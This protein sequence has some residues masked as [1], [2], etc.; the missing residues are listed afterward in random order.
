[1][2]SKNKTNN[3]TKK[4]SL[5]SFR[6]LQTKLL[7][8]FLLILLIPSLTI[9]FISYKTA[10]DEVEKQILKSVDDNVGMLERAIDD[11]ISS[12]V[13]DIE[14]LAGKITNNMYND[15]EIHNI[16]EL[17]EIYQSV[18]PD[19]S[20]VFTGN[21][22]GAYLNVLKKDPPK[23]YDARK[24]MW[25]IQ[26]M[27]KKGEVIISEPYIAASTGE[28]VITV[29][30]VNADKTGVIGIDISLSQL[31]KV[32]ENIQIGREGYGFILDQNKKYIVHPTAELGS[33]V[34]SN[35]FDQMYNN[36]EGYFETKIDGKNVA[37]SYTTDKLTG[38][39]VVGTI[40]TDEFEEASNPILYTTMIV[41]AVAIL[42]G[43][44]IVIYNSRSIMKSLKLL[45]ETA[46]KVSQG[47]LTNHVEI[48]TNDVIGKLGEAFNEMIDG[49]QN[50]THTMDKTAE[51]VASSSEELLSNAEET[52]AITEQ[53]SKS[54]QD[55]AE[56]AEKQTNVIEETS[57]SLNHVSE[58]ITKIAENSFEVAGLAHRAVVQAED[59]GKAVT[60]TVKQMQS[61]HE[62]V[63]ESH[64]IIKSLNESSKE[65]REILGVI[66][67]IADQT[68]LLALNAAIEA[69]RAGEH[70]KGFAVV[71]DE[72]RKLA[73]QSQASAKEIHAIITRIQSDTENT[74]EIMKHI[75]KDVENGV[76][77]TSEAIEQFNGI[78]ES[79]KEIAPKM[80]EVS[81]AAQRIS[82]EIQEIASSANVI[83]EI[84]Q[85]NAATS[86]EVAASA[87]EQLA[88]MEEISS[89][90]QSLAILADELK[91]IT[92]KFKR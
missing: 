83:V 5:F 49:L 50:I 7:V 88:S 76:E 19:V 47:D 79:T 42:F 58:K 37:I 63:R 21:E 13:T 68:N 85:S 18:N 62:L 87:E 89:S 16:S 29:S 74:V 67:G 17:F 34:D 66:S 53:V 25:Y 35:I 90:A 77:I 82:A 46:L 73:E 75:T 32:A 57:Q 56:S 51:Q 72:V 43:I 12:K 27:E 70:G 4:F 20:L 36:D 86:E 10:K 45:Q 41:M 22:E 23:G 26:A 65:V 64:E 81:E 9:G 78:F 71:A 14:F 40:Y 80:E 31:Q 59:G 54:I 33:E 91:E 28:M 15:D 69:A 61:I 6:N 55:V 60:N 11:T 24:R 52:N 48:N 38:W 39:K 2:K 44:L 30:K 3:P 1:M 92:N 84:S 8:S